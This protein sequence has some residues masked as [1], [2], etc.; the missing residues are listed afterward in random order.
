MLTSRPSGPDP[1]VIRRKIAIPPV[2]ERLVVRERID[3]LLRELIEA[4]PLVW[5]CASAGS[6]KTTAV[7]QALRRLERPVAWLTLDDTDAAAGRLVTYLEATLGAQVA[8]ARGVA[9]AA[10][11]ARLPH[12]EAA[13]LLAEAVGDV[14]VLLVIDELER[15]AAAPEAL[16]V[17][18][19]LVRYAPPA[20]R[21]VMVSRH[22]VE[23]PLDS[24]AALG[25]S[26]TVSEADLAFRTSEA[27]QALAFAGRP[28][29]DPSH[30]VE[31]TGGWVAGVLFEAW[32]STHHVAGMG[33]EAD[34]LHGYL[35]V[36]SSIS[37]HPRTA[38]S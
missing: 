34:A 7:T 30:A 33:G 31:V 13:G 1:Q 2:P 36:K 17:I 8:G 25:G 26:V 20:M 16:A 9:T 21:L 19:A 24:T 6:G 22:E 35:P 10:L 5:V 11:A 27:A 12:P 28:D 38:S 23:V 37:W 18:A 4:H 29:I 3:R 15:I 32:R 14:P